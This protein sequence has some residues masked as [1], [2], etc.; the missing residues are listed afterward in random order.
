MQRWRNSASA[1]LIG[2]SEIRAVCFFGGMLDQA[3]I[4]ESGFTQ[5]YTC[6]TSDS[7]AKLRCLENLNRVV[8]LHRSVIVLLMPA[9]RNLHW[10]GGL[11][12]FCTAL[13]VG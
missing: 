4:T 3:K 2:R 8:Y 11:S 1:A 6:V 12:D 13:L 10:P 9:I 5:V 7:V